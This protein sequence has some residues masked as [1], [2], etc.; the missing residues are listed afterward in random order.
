MDGLLIKVDG[1]GNTVWTKQYGASYLSTGLNS[2][3][4]EVLLG[5]EFDGAGNLV[6]SGIT[7]D[8][9]EANGGSY[10]AFMMVVNPSNGEVLTR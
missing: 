10:D 7:T 9:F 2:G 1:S 8:L 4:A 3:A 6:T 5:A